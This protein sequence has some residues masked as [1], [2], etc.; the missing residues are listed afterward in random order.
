[1]EAVLA[2]RLAAVLAMA[3]WIG[4]IVGGATVARADDFR[5]L[6]RVYVGDSDEPASQTTTIFREG[7]VYDC[8]GDP[9]EVVM[10]DPTGGRFVLL[11]PERK[12]RSEIT[13]EQIDA[14]TPTMKEKL[15][16][17]KD[18][19]AAFLLG[20]KFEEITNSETGETEFRS[21]WLSYRLRTKP[22]KNDD[23]ARQYAAFSTHYTRLNMLKHPLLLA[24]A[25]VNTW[26]NERKLLPEEVWLT[27]YKPGLLGR[28]TADA[29][30]RS[31]HKITWSMSSE[32]L[33]R[34]ED[35]QRWLVLF[36]QVRLL[37]YWN[38]PEP[39]QKQ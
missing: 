7:I 24:R 34:I 19:V 5:M 11:D 31:Q 36:E 25:H 38:K 17:R 9:E 23:V 30:F 32:D 13:L 33:Q 16:Q 29:Q 35:I 20:P 1:M 37:E 27:T 28:K 18:G 8:I 3:T 2:P 22:A 21:P 14:L 6:T 10:F 15:L 26:L 12:L 39:P 4:G